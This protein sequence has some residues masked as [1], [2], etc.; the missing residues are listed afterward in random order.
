MPVNYANAWLAPEKNF[1]ILVCT[2]RGGDAAF[3]ATDAAVAALIP[4]AT[5]AGEKATGEDPEAA[6]ALH[7]PAR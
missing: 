3:R 1:A 4:M 2:N 7:P 6:E 5:A